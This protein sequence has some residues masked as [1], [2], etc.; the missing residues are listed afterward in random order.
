MKSN[1]QSIKGLEGNT[2]F[3][4]TRKTLEIGMYVTGMDMGI[5]LLCRRKKKVVL[6]CRCVRGLLNM[7]FLESIENI[8]FCDD[9]NHVDDILV[10]IESLRSC[11][12]ASQIWKAA[13]LLK[14]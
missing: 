9:P 4:E 8:S 5:K 6:L 3:W 7:T 12:L 10:I 2:D 14:L 1:I 13:D 11:S